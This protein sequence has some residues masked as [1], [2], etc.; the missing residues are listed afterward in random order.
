MKKHVWLRRYAWAK[1]FTFFSWFHL[2]F[3][4]FWNMSH[5][6]KKHIFLFVVSSKSTNIVVTIGLIVAILRCSPLIIFAKD[7][8]RQKETSEVLV[9]SNFF[10]R[11]YFV[12]CISIFFFISKFWLVCNDYKIIRNHFL[13]VLTYINILYY[14]L[15]IP[16]WF[17]I[18]YAAYEDAVVGAHECEWPNF[19]SNVSTA[20]KIRFD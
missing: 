16:Y 18:V 4:K 3:L 2:F 7:I 14:S 15:L 1:R 12:C 6:W 10:R 9:V 17:L 20:A 5:I 19:C 13:C 11:Y 8:F